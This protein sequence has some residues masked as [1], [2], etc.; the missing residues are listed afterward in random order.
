[1]CN[2]ILKLINFE[3]LVLKI[4]RPQNS[5][6]RQT[7]TDRHFLKMVKSSYLSFSIPEYNAPELMFF[8]CYV[9][10]SLKSLKLAISPRYTLDLNY[11]QSQK[12]PDTT[13]GNRVR[14]AIR[15]CGKIVLWYMK[16]CCKN[17]CTAHPEWKGFRIA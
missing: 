5:T 8:T 2:W 4:Q 13:W 3:P 6:D 9:M 16:H 17:C 10:Q 12:S 1:M 11:P 14:A 15:K 7:Q